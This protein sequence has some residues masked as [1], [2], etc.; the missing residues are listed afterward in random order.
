MLITL[1]RGTTA[2]APVMDRVSREAFDPSYGEAWSASQLSNAFSLPNA[3]VEIAYVDDEAVS[4][5]LTRRILDEAE[6]LLIAVAPKWRGQGVAS[7]LMQTVLDTATA[8]GASSMFLEV[9]SGNTAASQLYTRFGFVPVG[10]RYGYY[11]GRDGTRFD[12]ITMRRHL[13]TATE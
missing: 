6:L 9:R 11:T 10:R 13:G 8:S 5:A 2:D 12:A 1:R 7:K 3:A 4:F